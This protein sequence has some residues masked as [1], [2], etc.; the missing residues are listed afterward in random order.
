LLR[1]VSNLNVLCS[2]DEESRPVNELFSPDGRENGNS[3]FWRMHACFGRA[4][5]YAVGLSLQQ[6]GA[7]FKP[8]PACFRSIPRASTPGLDPDCRV[9][10]GS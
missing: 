3:R 9:Q 6:A 10:G 2:F 1:R 4:G 8:A 7:G 5:G